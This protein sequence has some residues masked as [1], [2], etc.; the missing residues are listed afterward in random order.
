MEQKDA[1][2]FKEL[3]TEVAGRSGVS[4]E[5]LPMVSQYVWPAPEGVMSFTIGKKSPFNSPALVFAI[6]VDGDEARI[7]TLPSPDAKEEQKAP[8]R[9]I[10]QS[11]GRFG[12][13]AMPLDTFLD[14]VSEEVG[15]LDPVAEEREL[16]ASYLEGKAL[17][18]L[19][20]EIR[21]GAHLDQEDE[22]APPEE[23]PAARAPSAAPV[24]QTA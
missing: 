15:D 13:S 1:Y 11:A 2:S 7:Y 8:K 5:D 17:Q 22:L 20:D 3:W 9:Y 19:A 6:F 12:T 23:E 18:S 24:S 14:E 4:L 21:D 16:V 10:L